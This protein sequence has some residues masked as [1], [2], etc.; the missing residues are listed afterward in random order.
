MKLLQ[1]LEFYGFNI[2]VNAVAVSNNIEVDPKCYF[3][4]KLPAAQS[5][6]PYCSKRDVSTT[7]DMTSSRFFGIWVYCYIIAVFLMTYCF[8]LLF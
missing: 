5:K 2:Y 7:V 8:L 1:L 6:N 3:S 4:G